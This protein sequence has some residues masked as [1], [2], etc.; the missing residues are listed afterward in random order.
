[1]LAHFFER[2]GVA[3]AQAEAQFEHLPLP[4]GQRAEHIGQL[5]LQQAVTG[6]VRRIFG[7]LVLDKIAEVGVFAVAHG[8]LERDRLLRHLEHGPDALDRDLHFVGDFL[9]SGFAAEVLHELFLHP[10]QLVDRFDHVHRDAN[11]TGLVGDRTGDGLANPPGGVGGEFVAA[12]IF[13]FLNRLHQAH[14][15]LLDQVEEG[16][17]AVGV[18]FGDGNDQ[19]Q[20]GFDHFGLGLQGLS[21]EAL[22]LFVSIE[23]FLVRHADKFVQ[24]LDFLVLGL[25]DPLLLGGFSLVFPILNGLQAQLNFVVNVVGH[26]RHLFDDL[27]LVIKL[28]EG[29]LQSFVDPFEL[30][31]EHVPFGF[32]SAV[33]PF[34][35]FVI[36]LLVD[37]AQ[38]FDELAER[39]KMVVAAL[40]LFV[41]NYAVETFLGRFGNEFFGQC[42]V[43]LAGETEAV[44]DFFDLVFRVFNAFGNLHFLLAREQ[45][46]LAHLLEVHPNRVVQNVQPALV[47]LFFRLRLLD[48]VHFRLVNDFHFEVAELGVDL[49]QFLGRD[50]RVRQR[51]VDVVVSEVTLFL[52]QPNQFLDL[53]CQIEAGLAFDGAN[54][55]LIERAK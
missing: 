3:V 16:Q 24:R 40:D 49:I 27:L 23:V 44:D 4:L 8:G 18:F 36:H 47:L 53:L 55:L 50:H 21:G 32:L 20:V 19:A 39:A 33:L 5:V 17:A 22:Q 34:G 30:L 25:D 41:E 28:R 35:V 11:G 51:I 15:A 1:M 38:V 14:V 7:G 10:H 26:Q 46:D 12:A 6:H 48:A 43:L 13:E 52:G 9:R 31:E 2:A 29:S 45:R 54:R 37:E 42:D